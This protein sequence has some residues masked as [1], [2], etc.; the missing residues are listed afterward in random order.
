MIGFFLRGKISHSST[1]NRNITVDKL[2]WRYFVH[3]SCRLHIYPTN[4]RMTRF[5]VYRTTHKHYF[6][7]PSSKFL[8]NSQAHFPGWII[9][10]ETYGIYFFISRS[11][12]YYHLLI[13]K[14]C[15]SGK[16]IRDKGNN[17]FRFF[18]PSFP[19][20]ATSQLPTFRFDNNITKRLQH[21]QISLRCRMFIHIQIH[22]RSHHH[23]TLGR[24]ISCQQ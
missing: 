24:Q 20:Q 5:Q 2:F 21:L 13:F 19:N 11:R 4:R 17:L 8:R 14:I 23:R 9:P 15:L 12:C 16:I 6:C 1:Q 18:H 7:S 10:D 22:C 3:L